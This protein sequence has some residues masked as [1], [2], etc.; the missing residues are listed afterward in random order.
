M[1]SRDKAPVGGICIKEIFEINVVPFTF[2]NCLEKEEILT[3]S[4]ENFV[5]AMTYQFF[6][7]MMR[8]CFPEKDP[9]TLEDGDHSETGST[10]SLT[11]KGAKHFNTK[12]K[13]R[14]S[15]E[16]SFYVPIEDK[17]DVEKMKV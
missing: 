2:G 8:F 11:R 10:A 6:K 16:S 9:E 14:S 17:D 1:F 7:T 12:S 4:N 5:A 13:N 15:K 3:F